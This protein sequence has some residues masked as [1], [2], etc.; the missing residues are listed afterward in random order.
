MSRLYVYK[1]RYDD[2]TAP[3]VR[4]GLLS[5]ATCKAA[6]RATAQVGDTLV[7]FAAKSMCADQR[8]VY[9]A[10]V[11]ARIEHGEYFRDPAFR[12][13][14]DRVYRWQGARLLPRA[15][16]GFD[17]HDAL[18][19]LGAPPGYARAN[20][21]LSTEFRHFAQRRP[22]DHARFPALHRLIDTLGQGHRVNHGERVRDALEQYLAL[23]W[24]EP[25]MHGT[26]ANLADASSPRRA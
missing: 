8:L 18:Q 22:A 24:A 17:E 11:T 14:A 21:L 5:L 19:D 23:V 1:V 7:G 10:V 15:G 3:H 26:A 12:G 16:S 6:I 20:V 9:A 13:R 25:D 4:D 2:G